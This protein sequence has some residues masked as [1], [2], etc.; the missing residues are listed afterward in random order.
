MDAVVFLKVLALAGLYSVG[1]WAVITLLQE[2]S[3]LWPLPTFL[4]V[5]AGMLTVRL[6]LDHPTLAIWHP[7]M[8]SPR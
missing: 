6:Y 3:L 8:V 7:G 2:K 5:M 1:L 4:L